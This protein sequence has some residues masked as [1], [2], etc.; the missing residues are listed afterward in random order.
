LWNTCVRH[1]REQIEGSTNPDRKRM[2]AQARLLGYQTIAIAREGGRGNKSDKEELIYMLDL[3]LRA[4]R[5][6]LDVSDTESARWTLQ[7]AADLIEGLRS[8]CHVEPIKKRCIEPEAHY[9]IFRIILVRFPGFA[10]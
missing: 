9:L 1:E 4:S 10:R 2:F 6:C 5:A 8:H 3:I 7:R